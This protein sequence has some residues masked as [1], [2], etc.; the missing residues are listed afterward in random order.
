MTVRKL[1]KTR[2]GKILRAVIRQIV[3]GEKW[4]TPSTIEDPSTLVEIQEMVKTR[5]F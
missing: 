5:H 1:P 4:S 2:S 3:D